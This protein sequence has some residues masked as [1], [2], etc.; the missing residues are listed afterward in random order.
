MAGEFGEV[1]EMQLKSQVAF[2]RLFVMSQAGMAL[3][4]NVTGNFPPDGMPKNSWIIP[5]PWTSTGYTAIPHNRI[6][7]FS[8]IASITADLVT[9]LR[10]KAIN[11]KKY[12]QA[13]SLFVASLGIAALDQTFLS[14]LQN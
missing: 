6:Q 3:T 14:G 4:G 1:A 9:L 13:V 7:P 5:T 10:D 8:S 11:E 2:T 12:N